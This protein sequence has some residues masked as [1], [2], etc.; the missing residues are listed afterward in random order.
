MKMLLLALLFL[1]PVAFA[2]GTV[3]GNGGDTIDCQASPE[4]ALEG[5]YVLDYVLTYNFSN[6]NSDVVSQRSFE[7]LVAELEAKDTNLGASLR[8]F[9]N[10]IE[11]TDPTRHYLWRKLPL[12]LQDLKDESI[13]EIIPKNCMNYSQGNSQSVNIRQI[14]IREKRPNITIFNYDFIQFQKIS[15]NETQKSFIL[16]HEWLWNIVTNAKDN[17]VINRYLHSQS[18]QEDSSERVLYTLRKLGANI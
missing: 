13:T 9:A 18:F 16:I 5:T 12:G 3:V 4:N 14:I 17:R 6:S 10:E 7:D 1:Q 11:N 8:L 15:Q 2:S